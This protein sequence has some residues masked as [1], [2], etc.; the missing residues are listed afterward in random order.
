[1]RHTSR[2]GDGPFSKEITYCLYNGCR[3]RGSTAYNSRYSAGDWKKD[4]YITQI[5][6]HIINCQQGR[7]TSIE[8]KLKKSMDTKV[9]NLACKMVEDAYADTTQ[10]SADNNQTM[11]VTCSIS[12][13][14]QDTWVQ[15]AGWDLADTGRVCLHFE[16]AGSDYRCC[17]DAGGDTSGR[18][19]HCEKG[20]RRSA[21]TILVHSDG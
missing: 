10:V 5:A 20:G 2:P 4:Y 6:V 21:V 16:S 14:T 17:P 18:R 15:Q 12:P 7:E 19:E 9:Y 13:T 3:Y 11:E 8:K 1:M